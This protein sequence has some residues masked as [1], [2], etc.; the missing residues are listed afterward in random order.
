METVA[1]GKYIRISPR[2]VRLVAHLIQGKPVAEALNILTFTHK[3]AAPL[4]AKVLKSAVANAGQ[5]KGVDVDAL[6]VKRILIDQ[7]PTMKRFHA[8]AMGRGARILHRMSHI[9]VAVEE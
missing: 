6:M 3:R 5:K 7:G 2:K 9:T 8:R 1:V 4:I